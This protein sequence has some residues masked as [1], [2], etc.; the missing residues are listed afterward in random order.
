MEN[1]WRELLSRKRWNYSVG[2]GDL[3]SWSR[4][5]NWEIELESCWNSTDGGHRSKLSHFHPCFK[6]PQDN[7][8]LGYRYFSCHPRSKQRLASRTTYVYDFTSELATSV[9]AN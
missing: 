4:L 8:K 2:T 7:L 9:H 1:S 6:K 5:P 3:R